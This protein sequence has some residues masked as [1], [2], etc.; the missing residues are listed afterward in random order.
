MYENNRPAS[1]AKRHDSPE[2]FFMLLGAFLIVHNL[3]DDRLSLYIDFHSHIKTPIQA[4]C[5]VLWQ[6]RLM[7][8]G[9]MEEK[10]WIVSNKFDLFQ[11][12]ASLWL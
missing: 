2:K 3:R 7:F 9:T 1:K 10:N 5:W 8:E 6:G 11:L 4:I 12:D